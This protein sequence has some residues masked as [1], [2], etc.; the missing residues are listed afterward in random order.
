M[1]TPEVGK[2]APNFTLVTQD[3]V[4]F[5]LYD[6]IKLGPVVLVFYAMDGSP[7]C[8]KLLCRINADV[9]EFAA[10]GFRIVGVNY[11]EPDDHSRY[12]KSK[13]LRLQLLSDDQFRVSE[14]YDCLFS[15]GPIKVIRI[16]V[17]GISRDGIITYFKRGRPSNA[18]IIAGMHSSSASGEPA[19]QS[20]L[21]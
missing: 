2:V 18:E 12:A 10:A 9:D 16:S 21:Q 17:V 5:T 14:A 19:G 3:R 4:P 13:F 20:L 1:K 7:A 15:I 11:A 6:E 8:D